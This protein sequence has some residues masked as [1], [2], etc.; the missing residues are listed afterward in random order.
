MKSKNG[1]EMQRICC[2]IVLRSSYNCGRSGEEKETWRVRV[3]K[4]KRT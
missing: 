2:E 1:W 4:R 3:M